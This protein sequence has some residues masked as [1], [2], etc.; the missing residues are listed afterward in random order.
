MELEETIL[1][2]VCNQIRSFIEREMSITMVF[3][4]TIFLTVAA[5]KLF[6][7]IH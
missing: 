1:D 5:L 3:W 4:M 2:R 7:F 6:R